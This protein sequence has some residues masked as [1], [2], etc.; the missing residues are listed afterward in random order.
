MKGLKLPTLEQLRNMSKREKTMIA[1]GAVV[2][3][4]VATDRLVINPW[5]DYI[6]KTRKEIKKME[7]TVIQQQKLLAREEGIMTGVRARSKFFHKGES[8]ETD[9]ANFLRVVEQY[10]KSN[11]V[12][13]HEVRPLATVSTDYS[14]EYGLDV[15]YE[16]ELEPAV[17][18]I[19]AIET[20]AEVF[21][22]EKASIALIDQNSDILKGYLRIRR[23]ML[24]E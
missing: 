13:I 4:I 20:S 1:A 17:R 2:F 15:N 11:G 22:I 9:I 7:R 19:H 16:S 5:N 21:V 6:G 10:A 3:F 23:V 12:T 8:P 24:K 14:Q 18:F